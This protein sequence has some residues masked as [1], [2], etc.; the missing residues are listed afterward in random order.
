MTLLIGWA[1]KLVGERFARPFVFIIGLLL[2]IGAFY[3][4]LD[5]YGDSRFREGRAVENKAWKDAQD[6]LLKQAAES[7]TAADKKA[8][9]ATVEH[10]A[11][12]EEEK[13]KVDAA[14]A[15]GSSP[16]DVLFGA[17]SVQTGQSR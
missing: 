17:D 9:A 2:V 14:I 12:V 4:A 3:I 6:R 1:A 7:A 5:A 11:K 13:E 10:A 15:D 8:L 16:F